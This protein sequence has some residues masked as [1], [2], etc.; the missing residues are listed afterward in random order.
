MLVNTQRVHD[1]VKTPQ[2][3]A[4]LVYMFGNIIFLLKVKF[5]KLLLV[6]ILTKHH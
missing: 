5:H 4:Y 1:D 2:N 6:V 3:C